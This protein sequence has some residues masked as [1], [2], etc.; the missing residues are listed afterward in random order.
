MVWL[1]SSADVSV[2]LKSLLLNPGNCHEA[3]V[4]GA[5]GEVFIEQKVLG[6]GKIIQSQTCKNSCYRDTHQEGPKGS[7]ALNSMRD[8]E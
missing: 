4:R 6:P 8:Q 7:A 3:V 1:K 2:Q 5:R